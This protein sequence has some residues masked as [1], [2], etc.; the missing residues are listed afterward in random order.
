MGHPRR[1]RSIERWGNA[2]HFE[3]RD[4][5]R[6]DS[7]LFHLT[8]LLVGSTLSSFGLAQDTPAT[9]RYP[10]DVSAGDNALYVADLKL[11]GVWKIADG[12][13]EILV[14][15]QKRFRTPLN[16]IRCIAHSPAGLLLGDSATTT[17][18]K[19]Q[20]NKPVPAHT[21]RIG[22]PMA[23]AVTPDAQVLVADLELHRIWT[24]PLE[25]GPAKEFA[26]VPAPRG[27]TVDAEG[28]VWVVSHGKD[29]LIRLSPDGASREVVVSGRPFKF[30]HHVVVDAEGTA[31]V[32]DGYRKTIWRIP[33]GEKP[34][35][36]VR[37]EP[38]KNPVG[39]ALDGERLIVVDSHAKSILAI[40]KAGAITAIGAAP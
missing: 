25:G 20:D 31:F 16:A 14:Q 15:G 35:E 9:L 4:M 34:E 2:S 11:P 33:S 32:A 5:P 7:S 19:L 24:F 17:V 29:Q 28:R 36:L 8:V 38:L 22:I 18:Y 1:F 37:G 6:H 26:R 12:K 40:D 39:L 3:I 10:V 30:P 27:L 23:I 13:A 21:G